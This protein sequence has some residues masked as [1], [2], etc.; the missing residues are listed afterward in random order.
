MTETAVC[1]P[2]FPLLGFRARKGCRGPARSCHGA[3]YNW[4]LP[5][6][7]SGRASLFLGNIHGS[8]VKPIQFRTHSRYPGDF[9]MQL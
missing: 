3:F 8:R 1:F 2:R 7:S 6:P 4:L 9:W 5:A